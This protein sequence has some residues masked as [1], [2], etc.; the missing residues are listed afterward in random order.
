MNCPIPP[1][2]Q[3]IEHVVSVIKDKYMQA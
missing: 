2:H 3:K 1:I